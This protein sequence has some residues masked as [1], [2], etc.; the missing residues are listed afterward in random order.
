MDGFSYHMM[1]GYPFAGMFIWMFMIWVIQLIVGYFVY[2]DAGERQMSPVL[3]F[4]LVIIPAI[5]WLFLVIYL[6]IRETGHPPAPEKGSAEKILDE[7]FARGEITPE[8][9]RQMKEEL[10]K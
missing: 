7:R 2:R 10:K 8:E 6:I 5:G 1:Y 3:W 9:Y 4:I